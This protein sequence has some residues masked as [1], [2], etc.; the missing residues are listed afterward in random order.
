MQS[1]NSESYWQHAA[2]CLGQSSQRQTFST[3]T[4]H[5]GASPA[6]RRACVSSSR[7]M[8]RSSWR[9]VLGFFCAAAGVGGVMRVVVGRVRR[10]D[11]VRGHG[12]PGSDRARLCERLGVAG[13]AASENGAAA[14]AA[15]AFG[16]HFGWQLRPGPS[17]RW[18]GI[19]LTRRPQPRWQTCLP[20]EST[21]ATGP[22]QT[23][24]ASTQR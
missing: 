5:P 11:G 6:M 8:M 12:S 18:C 9:V 13:G 15:A 23:S 10:G 17:A 14:E 4:D 20:A 3:R 1:A 19:R 7:R 16:A 24:G 2:E 22:A 21:R